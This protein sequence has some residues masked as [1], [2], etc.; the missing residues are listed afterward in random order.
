MTVQAESP[1]IPAVPTLVAFEILDATNPSQRVTWNE[2]WERAGKGEIFAH[3]AY[4]TEIALPGERPHC[5]VARFDGGGSILYAFVVRPITTD[6]AGG[7]VSPGYQDIYTALVYG[8]PLA[9][10]V[11]D[12]GVEAFW[13]RFADWAMSAGVVSEII[14]F[15]PVPSR[16]LPYP[17]RIRVQ[18]PHVVRHLG[19]VGPEEIV[20][21]MRPNA[22][23]NLRQALKAGLSIEIDTT[24]E[25]LQE[26]MEIYRETMERVAA[27]S[28][29]LFRRELF[30]EIHRM[31]PGRF[32]YVYAVDD[33]R[34]ISVD[35]MLYADGVSYYFLGGTRTEALRS[36]AHVLVSAA[37]MRTSLERG[38]D[39][40]VLTGGVTNTLEDSLLEFKRRIAPD[41]LSEYA[42][43]ERIFL[44]RIYEELTASAP[45]ELRMSGF[46]P[47]YRAGDRSR[48][49]GGEGGR[50]DG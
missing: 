19:D 5:A 44:P 11:S 4:L 25:R 10:S 13:D 33:G 15:S 43:G 46:F 12:A 18:A 16:K 9:T 3:P 35:L 1:P 42:T 2:E 34:A 7:Q 29:F 40:H 20:S 41:G 6:S 14:R 21:E 49:S 22:R 32:A 23:R 48:R 30:E 24:G 31:F 17:G 50:D 47:L 45:D 38:C 27:D 26:F 28:R 36:G 37:A 8:G 39:H